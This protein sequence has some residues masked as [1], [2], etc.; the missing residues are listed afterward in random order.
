[1]Y[2]FNLRDAALA[3]RLA[4]PQ[5]KALVQKWIGWATKYRR[6]L[7]AEFVTLEH[8][9]DCSGPDWDGPKPNATCTRGG[10]DVILHRAPAHY[11]R[12]IVERGLVR[13]HFNQTRHSTAQAKPFC[14]QRVYVS[15]FARC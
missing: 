5:S 2:D 11:Y 8:G 12:D 4:G 10:L 15:P 9:T 14:C 7:S 6:V 13:Q 1:M 3:G